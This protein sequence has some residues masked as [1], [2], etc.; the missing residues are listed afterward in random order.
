M[1]VMRMPKDAPW[2][3]NFNPTR[4]NIKVPVIRENTR[5]TIEMH[6]FAANGHGITIG[7]SND[8]HNASSTIGNTDNP[9]I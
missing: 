1:A 5:G 4:Y 6:D 8:A 7:I 9:A 2:I 3:S